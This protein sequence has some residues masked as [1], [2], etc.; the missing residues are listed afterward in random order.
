MTDKFEFEPSAIDKTQHATGFL[1][2]HENIANHLH[3][4]GLSLESLKNFIVREQ[5]IQ[6]EELENLGHQFLH[7]LQTTKSHPSTLSSDNSTMLNVNVKKF[8]ERNQQGRILRK[9]SGISKHIQ[10]DYNNDSSSSSST[11]SSTDSS[12]S[13]NEMTNKLRQKAINKYVKRPLKTQ[14]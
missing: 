1:S 7:I 13:D 10:N 14:F 3:I 9:I 2:D 4:S 12:D 5:Q 6:E 11:S 8:E